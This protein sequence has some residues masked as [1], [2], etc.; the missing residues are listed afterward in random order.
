VYSL[1]VLL[2]LLVSGV[3]PYELKE[4]TTDE[5]IQTLCHAPVPRPSRRATLFKLD[6]DVDAIVLKALRRNRMSVMPAWFC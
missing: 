2:F 4:F 1:G 3:L 6:S 5:M